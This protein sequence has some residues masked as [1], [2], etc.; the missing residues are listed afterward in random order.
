MRPTPALIHVLAL[1]ALAIVASGCSTQIVLPDRALLECPEPS[2]LCQPGRFDEIRIDTTSETDFYLAIRRVD[3]LDGPANEFGVGFPTGPN[4]PRSGY[5]TVRETTR[6]GLITV[7]FE[8]YDRAYTQVRMED[9]N[10]GSSVGAAASLGGSDSL[11]FTARRPGTLRGDY[12]LYIGVTSDDGIGSLRRLEHSTRRFWDAQP[13]LSPDGRELYFASDRPG[14]LGGVDLYVSRRNA[15]GR[16][17][18]AVNL[19]PAVN[20]PCDELTPF[21]SSDGRWLY[22]SSSGHATV[23]GYD[24]FRARL[25]NAEVGRAENIGRP[26]NTAADEI[27]PSSPAGSSPDTLLYY[28]SNQEGSLKF[29]VYVLHPLGMRRATVTTTR[30]PASETVVL[31]G[32]VRN[33]EGLPVDSALVRLEQRDPPGPVDS[34]VTKKDGQYEFRIEEGKTYDLTA[35]S[36]ESLYMREEIRIPRSNTEKTVRR[37]VNLPDTV[38]FR[39][40]FPFNNATDPYEFTLDDRGMPSGERWTEVIERSARFLS[41]LDPRDGHRVIIVGHTDPI[42]SV[43]F[44]EN[45]GRRRAEFVRRELVAR[46]VSA[47]LLSVES[48]GELRPLAMNPEEQDELYRARLRRV[49]LVRVVKKAQ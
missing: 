15:S 27:F 40:N 34:T 47:A 32:T 48:E 21:V 10:D 11:Y 38:T 36:D 37:D 25:A 19:G 24:I 46:G 33:A 31:R 3:G 29:D 7:A 39:I 44:N 9:R 20:T 49:D 35:G 1:S 14:G 13:A 18:R 28:G 30:R 12:D 22:F 17:G 45:L 6:D 26:V 2:A 41:R 16:W 5:A 23:G 8:D 42:G 4:A 43:P